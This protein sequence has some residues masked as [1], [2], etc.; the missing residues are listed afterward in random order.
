M[1]CKRAQGEPEKTG[2]EKTTISYYYNQIE[3]SYTVSPTVSTLRWIYIMVI[4]QNDTIA[5]E[6]FDHV[7]AL[8]GGSDTEIENVMAEHVE[9]WQWIWGNGG[10][11]ITGDLTLAKTICVSL[12]YIYSNL[13]TKSHYRVNNHFYGL[14]PGSLSRGQSGIDYYGH[15][16]WDQ[17]TWMYPAILM[18]REDLARSMLS[19]RIRN[20]PEAFVRAREDEYLG[21]RFPWESAF[22]GVEVTPDICLLCRDNQ[23]HITGDISFAARQYVAATRDVDWLKTGQA[24]SG[25]TGMKF[26]RE[27]ARFWY[28]RPDYNVTKDRYVINSEYNQ[29]RTI[30]ILYQLYH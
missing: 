15:V 28:S 14:S 30:H 17:E 13:P 16:F 22:T 12:Y 7:M 9:E 20:M 18:F 11:E 19:Y 29:Y 25:Y 27:M 8:V 4:D 26:I 24:G 6:E 5:Q 10:I 2:G 1:D 21:T 3:N 23:Q